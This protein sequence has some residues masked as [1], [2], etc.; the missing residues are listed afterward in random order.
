MQTVIPFLFIVSFIGEFINFSYT[1]L[2]RWSYNSHNLERDTSAQI[3][4]HVSQLAPY[5]RFSRH[6]TVVA[7]VTSPGEMAAAEGPPPLRQ[8]HANR[9]QTPQNEIERYLTTLVLFILLATEVSQ[10][11]YDF[12]VFLR[13]KMCVEYI[14]LKIKLN[15]YDWEVA[16]AIVFCFFLNT[17]SV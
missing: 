7:L 3:L 13:R 14:L 1:F 2:H 15:F 10:A 12:E 9:K 5:G 11:P 4:L 6:H 17:Y 8:C 16:C